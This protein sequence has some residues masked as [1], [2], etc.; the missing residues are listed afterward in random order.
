MGRFGRSMPAVG[1][2]IDLDPLAEIG[3]AER[4]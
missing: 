3:P 2:S 1:F 4:A